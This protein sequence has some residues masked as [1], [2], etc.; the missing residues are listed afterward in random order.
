MVPSGTYVLT[1]SCYTPTAHCDLGSTP[2]P[3]LGRCGFSCFVIKKEGLGFPPRQRGHSPRVEYFR[4]S[5]NRTWETEDL[6]SQDSED[7]FS[8]SWKTGPLLFLPDTSL[9][10]TRTH[11]LGSAALPGSGQSKH[12]SFS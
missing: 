5:G 3:S 6:G 10:P 7:S 1:H 2:Q 11:A 12:S 4:S 9:P 8:A